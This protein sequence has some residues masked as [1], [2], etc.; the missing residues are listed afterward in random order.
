MKR[1]PEDG[2]L[3]IKQYVARL[4]LGAA[5]TPTY[6]RQALDSFRDTALRY[7]TTD[8][9]TFEH[10]LRER[11]EVWA[12]SAVQH[13]ARIIT[14]FLNILAEDGRIHS[15]PVSDLRRGLN[16]YSD[17]SIIRALMKPDPEKA[18]KDLC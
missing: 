12:C 3:I 18:L 14:R 6:Y 5:T 15:N 16:A 2:D 11:C 1:W 8:R 17:T 10:W 9:K 13:R 4:P 7:G